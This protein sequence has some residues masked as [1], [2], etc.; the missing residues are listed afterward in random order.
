MEGRSRHT[1]EQEPSLSLLILLTLKR[2][3]LERMLIKTERYLNQRQPHPSLSSI[4]ITAKLKLSQE[5]PLLSSSHHGV[6]IVN[7]LLLLGRNLRRSMKTT[8]VLLLD[9]LIAQPAIT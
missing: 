2:V 3:K 6:V 7:A 4:K 9:M 5:L 1:K 8:R